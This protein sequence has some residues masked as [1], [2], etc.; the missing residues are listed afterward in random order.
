MATRPDRIVV[1]AHPDHIFYLANHMAEDDCRECEAG[2]FGPY[3][4]LK[5]S[6][7]MSVAAWTGMVGDMPVVMFGVTPWNGI[8]SGKGSPWLL[9]T[10]EL[11]NHKIY[12]L[13]RNREFLEKMQVLF[14]ELSG[15]VDI[16]HRRGIRWLRWLGFT[17]GPDILGLG[18]CAMPFYRF[19]KGT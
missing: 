18:P 8:L 5:D 19:H 16:R 17:V 6:L 9:G 15:V 2:G 12:F 13:K 7:D 4:A 11:K 14:P 1:P 10:D 3:R